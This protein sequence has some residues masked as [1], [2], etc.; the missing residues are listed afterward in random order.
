[1]KN[2]KSIL[3]IVYDLGNSRE[4]PGIPVLYF[5][6]WLIFVKSLETSLSPISGL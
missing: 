1:M 4:F 3:R 6:F 2:I 5:E